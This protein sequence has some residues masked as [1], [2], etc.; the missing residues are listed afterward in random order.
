MTGVRYPQSLVA[1]G[2]LALLVLSAGVASASEEGPL[3]RGVR[4]ET[5][6]EGKVGVFFGLDGFFIPSCFGI[7][8]ETPRFVCDFAGARLGEGVET[9]IDTGSPILTGVRIAWHRVPPSKV[10]VVLDLAPAAGFDIEQI[11]VEE[12]NEYVLIIRPE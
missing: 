9:K 4:V 12:K 2:V 6:V 1:A 11:F 5:G 7:A 3:L 10:R 8:G